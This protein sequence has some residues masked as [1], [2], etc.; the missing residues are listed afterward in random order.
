MQR[1]GQIRGY[2]WVCLT[3]VAWRS[4]AEQNAL[5]PATRALGYRAK[6]QRTIFPP[7]CK[8]IYYIM[9]W[10]TSYNL[11]DRRWPVK[12]RLHLCFWKPSLVFLNWDLLATADHLLQFIQEFVL[13]QG[14][15]GLCWKA[16]V[17]QSFEFNKFWEVTLFHY[18]GFLRSGMNN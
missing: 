13:C 9:S 1:L 4:G 6:K 2:H 10:Y 3:W 8:T 7:W 11:A 12:V 14:I 18:H 15:K 17:D 16:G 5:A